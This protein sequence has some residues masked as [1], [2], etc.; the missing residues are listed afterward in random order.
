M[1]ILR[2]IILLLLFCCLTNSFAAENKQR[3]KVALVLAGGGAKG[4]AHIGV[5]KVLEKE[6]I[7]VDIVVGT[8]IGSVVGGIY[9]MG[10]K[11]EQI[12]EL[13]KT[14]N[15]NNLFADK[16]PR[17][18]QSQ[19]KQTIDQRYLLSIPMEEGTL[20]FPKAAING[21]NL[22]NFFCSL[23]AN[24]PEKLDFDKLPVQYASVA[25]NLET[26][27]KV[28]LRNGFLPLAMYAS[29]SIPGVFNPCVIDNKL[30]I[31]GGVVDN[32]PVD[33]A[34]Q[35]GADIIIGVDIRKSLASKEELNTIPKV[36]TQMI[37]LYDPRTDFSP[38]CDNNGCNVFISPNIS[39]FN[40]ASF[41]PQAVDTLVHRGED[42]AQL[43]VEQLRALKAKY[44]LN[45]SSRGD[46]VSPGFPKA[47]Y[48]KDV[49]VEGCTNLCKSDIVKDMQIQLPNVLSYSD[50]KTAIDK[51]YGRENFE[52]IYFSLE[53]NAD[54]IHSKNLKLYVSEKKSYTQNIGFKV[55]TIDAASIMLNITRTDNSR[56][57]KLLS[58]SAELSANPGLSLVGELNNRNF[59]DIG[60]KL[61]WK[62]QD[63]TLYEYKN[64]IGSAQLYYTGATLYF[65]RTFFYKMNLGLAVSPQYFSGKVFLN[66]ELAKTIEIKENKNFILDS[67]L[68]LS[69]D[70]LDHY[71]FPTTGVLFSSELSLL[72]NYTFYSGT[73]TPALMASFKGVTSVTDK[74]A[75]ISGFVAR[76]IYTG[77]FSQYKMNFVGGT[78]YSNYFNNQIPFLGMQSATPVGRNVNVISLGTRY[79]VIRKHYVLFQLNLLKHSEEY[80]DFSNASYLLGGGIS[81]QI[82]TNMGPLDVTV[83]YSDYLSYPSFSANLGYW[84]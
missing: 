46:S 45:N 75:L 25:T 13:C 78:D 80:F 54:S 69:Y 71:Y 32:F 48:I 51:L 37:S 2:S 55:N 43:V 62:T 31:D 81:Y 20:S 24:Y 3:P 49:V 9:A 22:I 57:I 68:Y 73:Y 38:G 59:P 79:N 67:K 15:W 19:I 14:Q 40:N 84:F 41:S 17:A 39:G 1:R 53:A 58:V 29:M 33:V 30:L 52:K 34:K 44:E 50:V 26:G 16:V 70:N 23:S 76:S 10:Y 42:A 18:Y 12:E 6:D 65:Y 56:R 5:L 72:R 28:V 27:E 4:F 8:S 82:R 21:H 36:L 77:D 60:L 61:D 74:L 66:D 35:M 47:W 7:P 83:G 63:Y 11:P 64:E